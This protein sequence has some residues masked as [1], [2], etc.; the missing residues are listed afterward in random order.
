MAERLYLISVAA[1]GL[2]SSRVEEADDLLDAIEK[3]RKLQKSGADR[4]SIVLNAIPQ[5]MQDDYREMF[6]A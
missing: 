2:T 1:L 5:V 6:N 4:I 3:T